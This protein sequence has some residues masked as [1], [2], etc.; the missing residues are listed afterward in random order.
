MFKA[1]IISATGLEKCKNIFLQAM[2]EMHQNFP[3]QREPAKP[4][5]PKPSS[6]PSD[7][8]YH[9]DWLE[10]HTEMI[11]L[12]ENYENTLIEFNQ[13]KEKTKRLKSES[14]KDIVHDLINYFLDNIYD[15][16][17]LDR[18]TISLMKTNLPQHFVDNHYSDA[19]VFDKIYESIQLLYVLNGHKFTSDSW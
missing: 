12:I 19:E 14:K 11:E 7:I 8:D 15:R 9:K 5:I 18:D 16:E 3:I 10:Y 13:E 4:H 6:N 2:L 17:N 1:E